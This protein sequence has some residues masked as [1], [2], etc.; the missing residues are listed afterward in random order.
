MRPT[1]SDIL[2]VSCLTVGATV[3]QAMGRYGRGS[4]SPPPKV[5]IARMLA[6]RLATEHGLFGPRVAATMF[7]CKRTS[8]ISGRQTEVNSAIASARKLLDARMGS[9]DYPTSRGA[10]IVYADLLRRSGRRFPLTT[11]GSLVG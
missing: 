9:L 3:A 4:A 7:G 11:H 6:T 10:Q 5:K 1:W 2:D 8:L